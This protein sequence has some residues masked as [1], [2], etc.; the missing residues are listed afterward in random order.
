MCDLEFGKRFLDMM[1][2]AWVTEDKN[3][4]LN[5]IKLKIYASKDTIKKVEWQSTGWE[6]ILAN[7]RS[8]KGLQEYIKN[9][10]GNNR[11]IET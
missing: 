4:K 2:K 11:K 6:Q 7:Y 8:D 9:N 10:Y 1:L 3:N 5:F